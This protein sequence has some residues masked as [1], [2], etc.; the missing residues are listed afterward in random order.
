MLEAFGQFEDAM[1][2]VGREISAWMDRCIPVLSKLWEAMTPE[3]QRAQQERALRASRARKRARAA[4]QVVRSSQL[5]A[6]ILREERLRDRFGPYYCA[7]H[8][9]APHPVV[10][11]AEAI[12]WRKSQTGYQ[13]GAIRRAVD[14][15]PTSIFVSM[16][17]MLKRAMG[18]F[19]L[20][21]RQKQSD[22]NTT[23]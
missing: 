20:P 16:Q 2:A 1:K 7:H 3:G 4:T 23:Q 21:K 9:G 14:A 8:R 12:E 17:S 18:A 19:T 15:V 13:P 11:T 22:P 5:R 6:A 10:E